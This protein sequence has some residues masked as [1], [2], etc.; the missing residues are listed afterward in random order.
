MCVRGECIYLFIGWEELE[1]KHNAPFFLHMQNIFTQGKIGC[2]FKQID[3][4][5]GCCKNITAG[6]DSSG[7][8]TVNRAKLA[9]DAVRTPLRC[10]GLTSAAPVPACLPRC[11]DLPCGERGAWTAGVTFG[12]ATNRTCNSEQ[13]S[14][15]LWDM[16]REYWIRKDE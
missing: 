9:F 11:L 6:R 14:S 16:K 3:F 8:N 2:C 1:R 12:S 4:S 10:S 5:G 13:V 15:P 7:Q